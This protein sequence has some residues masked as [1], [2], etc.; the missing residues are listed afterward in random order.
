MSRRPPLPI[1]ALALP[2]ALAA[3]GETTGDRR[4][5]LALRDRIHSKLSG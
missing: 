4:P 3:R 1:L 2:F 5:P